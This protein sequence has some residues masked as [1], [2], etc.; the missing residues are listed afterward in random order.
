MKKW[1]KVCNM[2]YQ[3]R[4]K[5]NE[6]ILFTLYH[7]YMNFI[8]V[9]T[10]EWM[11]RKMSILTYTNIYKVCLYDICNAHISKQHH[12]HHH[13]HHPADICLKQTETRLQFFCVNFLLKEKLNC[14]EQA[15][16]SFWKVNNSNHSENYTKTQLTSRL[17][18]IY[19]ICLIWYLN[20]K[21]KLVCDNFENCA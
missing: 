5:T 4:G 13:H 12:H 8:R 17:P 1:L 3:N 18:S 2:R 16:N 14:F 10:R 9:W 19:C 15:F 20:W 6:Q 21:I 7:I 11:K